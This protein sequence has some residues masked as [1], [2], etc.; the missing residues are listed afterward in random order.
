MKK[1][2]L[3]A[4]TGICL[5]SCGGG[6]S[7][8]EDM[9]QAPKGWSDKDVT[10][11]MKECQEDFSESECQCVIDKAQSKFES[12]QIMEDSMEN[13]EHSEE[14]LEELQNWAIK[15]WGDCGIDL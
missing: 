8:D 6:G 5:I 13:E 14:E 2:L 4:I 1:L 12:Y 3:L 10:Q 11:A 7:S 9:V 15:T